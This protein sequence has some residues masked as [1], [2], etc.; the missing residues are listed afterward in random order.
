MIRGGAAAA[1][2]ATAHHMN[3]DDGWNMMHTMYVPYHIYL[4]GFML[5]CAILCQLVSP[6]MLAS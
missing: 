6:I 3:H 5:C 1:A 2:V 4:T